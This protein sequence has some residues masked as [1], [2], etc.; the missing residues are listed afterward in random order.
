MESILTKNQKKEVIKKMGDNVY[1]LHLHY[2]DECNNGHNTFSITM[3]IYTLCKR[4]GEKR[5]TNIHGNS[6]WLESCGCQHD[7]VREIFPEYAHLIK[8]HV[9]SSVEPLHYLA[10]SQYWALQGNLSYARNSAVW[11][12]AGL[13]DILDTAAMLKRLPELMAEFKTDMEAVGFIF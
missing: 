9:C 6:V 11:S 13:T 2:D 7:M 5:A 3:D 8:W 1:I 4:L 12:T 10:N